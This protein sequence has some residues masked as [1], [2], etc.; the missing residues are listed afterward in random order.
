MPGLKTVC[1]ESKSLRWQR[2]VKRLVDVTTASFALLVLMP[3]LAVIACLIRF[4]MGRPVL[5][6]QERGGMAKKPFT[7]VKFRTMTDRKGSD[8]EPLPDGCRLSPLGVFLR[9]TSL[10]E[11]PQLWNVVKGD[12]SLVGPRPLPLRYLPYFTER[13]C[14]RFTVLPGIT[15]WAQ[16]HGRN[17]S[18]WSDRFTRDVWYVQHWSLWLDA[19]IVLRTISAVFASKGVVADARSIMLNLDEERRHMTLGK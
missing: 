3:L 10:D 1:P 16:I 14:L 13:E 12:I 4:N 6:R 7:V 11:L 17:E 9:K 2:R 5:F 19:R 8:G 15:G 18:S